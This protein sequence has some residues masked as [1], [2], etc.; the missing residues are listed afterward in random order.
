MG[1]AATQPAVHMNNLF[2]Y[3]FNIVAILIFHIFV[4]LFIYLLKVALFYCCIVDFVVF[5]LY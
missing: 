4:H 3:V 2:I 1:T 5:H